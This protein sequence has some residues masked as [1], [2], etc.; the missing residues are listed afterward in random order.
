M[1]TI[2]HRIYLSALAMTVILATAVLAINGSDYYLTPMH[3]RHAHSQYDS[4]KP[5]GIL[6]IGRAHV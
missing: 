5:T 6:E 4:L 3:E 1:N 2:S